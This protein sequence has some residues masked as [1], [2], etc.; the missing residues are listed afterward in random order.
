MLVCIDKLCRYALL[1]LSFLVPVGTLLPLHAFRLMEAAIFFGLLPITLVTRGLM[2]FPPLIRWSFWIGLAGWLVSTLWSPARGYSFDVGALEFLMFYALLYLFASHIR[3]RRSFLAALTAFVGGVLVLSIYQAISIIEVV[4]LPLPRTASDFIEYKKSIPV[5][6]KNGIPNTYGNID[7]YISI[8]TLLI[9]LLAGL[10]YAVRTWWIVVL[11]LFIMSYCGLLVYSRVGLIAV[12]LGLVA[13]VAFRAYAYRKSS[14]AV[15]S[16]MAVLILIHLDTKSLSY[17]FGG[18]A[19]FASA[20]SDE[21]RETAREGKPQVRSSNG[22]ASPQ[23]YPS[24]A[25]STSPQLSG[26]ADASAVGRA[27]AWHYGLSIG[28]EHWAT[29]IGY[30][31]YQNSE[32]IFTAPHSMALNRVAEG[33]ILSLISFLLL[34]AYAP[35][36]FARMVRYKPSMLLAACLVGISTFMVKALP[37]GATFAV[38]SNF[39]WGLGLALVMAATLI[40]DLDASTNF[41]SRT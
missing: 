17:L 12:M 40:P 31:R 1:A 26:S 21:S 8:W 11:A 36:R 7:N 13:L 20:V 19:S 39:V 9:P 37:F 4:H 24:D 6:F 10:L 27:T 28:M 35:I 18:A 14:F 5:Y 25:P 16:I 41:D 30:G 2:I 29:G 23:L 33:G 3:D 15:C 38:S 22:V 32:P 34:A